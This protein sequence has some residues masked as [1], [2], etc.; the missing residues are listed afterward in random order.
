MEQRYGETKAQCVT[1]WREVVKDFDYDDHA[2]NQIRDKLSSATIHMNRGDNRSKK[3]LLHSTAANHE[4]GL[5]ADEEYGK[6]KKKLW[7]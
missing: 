3:E 4:R 2:E 1:K 5:I 6:W 7:T